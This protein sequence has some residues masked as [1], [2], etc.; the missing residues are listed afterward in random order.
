MPAR[1][2]TKT[3]VESG[4]Y[5]QLCQTQRNA[6]AAPDAREFLWNSEQQAPP[7]GDAGAARY[8]AGPHVGHPYAD[9]AALDAPMMADTADI[10]QTQE[11]AGGFADPAQ[12]EA[13]VVDFPV[14]R[15][16][17]HGARHRRRCGA[18]RP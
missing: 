8:S 11:N 4:F 1:E 13:V 10:N 15:R 14:R 12:W 6:V 18:A 17:G 5:E 7:P 16:E 9:C 3:H 2:G